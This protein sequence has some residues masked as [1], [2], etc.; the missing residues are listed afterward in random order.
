MSKK[1][2][3]HIIEWTVAVA[4][5]GYLAY[6]LATY[7][8]YASL[9][10]SLRSMG[11]WQWLALAGSVA[12]MPVNMLIEA[13]KWTTLMNEGMNEL[14]NERMSWQ[15]AQRQVYYSKLAGLI[16]P[17][18]LGE[19][20][21]RGV[22]MNEGMNELTNESQEPRVESL[23]MK[24]ESQEIWAKVLSMGAV[25]SAT[26]T[27]AI[28]ASGLLAMA[29]GYWPL[30]VADWSFSYFI[31]IAVILLLLGLALYFSPRLLKRWATVS[32]RLVAVSLGQSF[33]RL[34]CWCIQLALILWAVDGLDG[35]ES[36]GALETLRTVGTETAIYYL[37]VTITPNIPIVEVGVRGAWAMF[38]FGTANA[39]LAGVLLWAINT[40]LPCVVALP[41]LAH[42]PKHRFSDRCSDG[43][44]ILPKN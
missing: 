38:V 2:I 33:L 20:P 7:D 44:A 12:L 40:L 42:A 26:M 9:A 10:A 19:Y 15:E 37:L 29:I 14:T 13:W 31:G 35:I 34:L 8:D 24:V 36:L 41:I 4:A 5:Y 39:A 6:R 32:H 22:L 28:I 30:A 16:T 11:V 17:W 23:E 3:L 1:T 18:R 25:G 27:T 43:L 21:A